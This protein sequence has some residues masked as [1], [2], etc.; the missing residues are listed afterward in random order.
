MSSLQLIWFILI[1]VLFAGYF[2][3]DG[4]D[5]GTGMSMETL[6]YNDNE[7]SQLVNTI[8]P[9]WDGNE[10]WLI[11]AGGAMFASFPYWYST[12][13]SGYYI[14]LLLILAGLIIRGV[15]FE[16][17]GKSPDKY[18]NI[19][20]WT[21]TIGSFMVPF[22]FGVMFMSMIKGMP[23]TASGNIMHANFFDYINWF[24]IVGGIAL[25]LLCYLHGLNYIALKTKITDAIHYR[26]LNYSRLI[27]WILYIGL[28]I[29][30]IML[31]CYT[32]FFTLHPI[33]T[34]TFLILIVI[35]TILGH[36]FTFHSKELGAFLCTGFSLISL[37]AL[38]FFGLFPRVMVADNP[39]NSLLIKNA[40]STPYTL[41]VM[42]ITALIV[43]P[44][45][46]AYTI[47]AYYIL[48]RRISY[49]DA[50]QNGGY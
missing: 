47:W 31:A 10:V 21:L 15:S 13:F 8:G 41:K 37:V 45:V 40:S 18:K 12:L 38:I 23:I 1:G 4:F 30:A 35:L 9:V 11:T 29:F 50:K 39:K 28:V 2:F 22:L 26:A 14:I 43:L 44:L 42:F 7:R 25:T 34:W 48:R 20:N 16:F 32:D 36:M 17:R 5:L 46:L 6:A 27:Y 24:S 49:K 3:L 33:S 19:W